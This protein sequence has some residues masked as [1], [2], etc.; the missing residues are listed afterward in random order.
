QD[1]FQRFPPSII[2]TDYTNERTFSEILIKHY[3]ERKVEPVLFTQANKLRLKQ[4]GLKILQMGYK[5]PARLADSQLQS[6]V[7]ELI[8]QLKH[9]QMIVTP[10]GRPSF[11]HP[12]GA[13]NDLAIAWEL[14][15]H[16]CQKLMSRPKPS[17]RVGTMGSM[18][19]R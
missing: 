16:G 1:L 6:W 10:S 4:E 11:N 5:F 19:V 8:Q 12:T 14:S 2:V 15:V 17:I 7:L 3:G 13:H 18:A 9:E